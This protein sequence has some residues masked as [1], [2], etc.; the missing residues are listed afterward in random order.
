M[1]SGTAPSEFGAVC[2]NPAKFQVQDP[3]I[4]GDTIKGEVLFTDNFGNCVTNISDRLMKNVQQGS[5]LDLF[6]DTTHLP[7]TMGLTYSSVPVGQNVCFINSSKRLEL[8]VNYGNFSG[9]YQ[10]SA[11]SKISLVRQ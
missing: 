8:S 1:I 11:S 3:A 5:V 10:I 2:A 4:S 9:K 6:S 7:I